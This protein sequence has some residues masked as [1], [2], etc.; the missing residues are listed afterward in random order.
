MLMKIV[1]CEKDSLPY[2][3]KDV[4]SSVPESPSGSLC[5]FSYRDLGTAPDPQFSRKATM[6]PI[7]FQ[8]R[9]AS[10]LLYFGKDF[11]FVL[12]SQTKAWFHVEQDYYDSSLC[13]NSAVALCSQRVIALSENGKNVRSWSV[14]KMKWKKAHTKKTNRLCG[15][16]VGK[17]VLSYLNSTCNCKDS[18]I[19]L[20]SA[21]GCS[22][23][24]H[25]KCPMNVWELRCVSDSSANSLH[26]EWIHT[27]SPVSIALHSLVVSFSKERFLFIENDG[28]PNSSLWMMSSANRSWSRMSGNIAMKYSGH[29]LACHFFCFS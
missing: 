20:T 25:K 15:S 5:L 14:D 2:Y 10:D 26:Y 4:E 27:S 18:I 1:A 12:R 23:S 9:N 24:S 21:R 29:R 28:L 6:L 16:V 17:A 8:Y 22:S 3:V 7:R 19:Y 13:I 11:T